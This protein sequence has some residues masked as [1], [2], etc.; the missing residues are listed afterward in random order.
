MKLLQDNVIKIAGFELDGFS[1]V[2]IPTGADYAIVK[3]EGE[4]AYRIINSAG[5]MSKPFTKICQINES[6]LT[7]V[8]DE[9]PEKP[10]RFVDDTGSFSDRYA[11]VST[12]ETTFATDAKTGKSYSKDKS[13][14][15]LKEVELNEISKITRVKKTKDGAWIN[16]TSELTNLPLNDDEKE[17]T[18]FYCFTERDRDVLLDCYPEGYRVYSRYFANARFATSI[19]VRFEK[20]LKAELT[21]SEAE[22]FNSNREKQKKIE[23]AGK[24]YLLEHLPYCMKNVDES[25]ADR[26]QESDAETRKNI[27]KLL[28]QG[29]LHE[30]VAGTTV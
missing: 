3:L 23:G 8:K 1:W 7:L 11:D 30:R 2:K 13:G 4:K 27:L 10:Y 26:K 15:R 21:A 24:Y 12:L 14:R 5:K 16:I 25:I 19:R 17:P 20:Q 28:N 6:G 29:K 18:H 9:D 22:Y